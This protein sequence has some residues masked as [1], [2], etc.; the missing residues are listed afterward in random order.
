[1]YKYVIYYVAFSFICNCN[2]A[3]FCSKCNCN[4]I[5]TGLSD[6]DPVEIISSQLTQVL[7]TPHK[8]TDRQTDRQ[9]D[10]QISVVIKQ[11]GIIN[12]CH[13]VIR[14][15]WAACTILHTHTHTQTYRHTHTS[16]DTALISDNYHHY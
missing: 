4:L 5:T 6:C 11:S 8:H 3:L 15:P 1:M 13:V 12:I 14:P 10:V 7:E 9:S 16:H 2:R